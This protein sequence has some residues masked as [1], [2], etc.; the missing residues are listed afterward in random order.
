MVGG[1]TIVDTVEGWL[2]WEHPNYPAYYLPRTAFA[3]RALNPTGV[4]TVHPSLGESELCDLMGHEG[5]ARLFG[6]G[7]GG[8][9][10]DAVR[11][12]WGAVDMWF[13][14]DKQVFVH[15]KDPY[16]RVDIL[17]SS[18]A[19]RIELEGRVLADTDRGTLVLETGLVARWYVPRPDV[20][21][22]LLM[23]STSRTHCPYKGEAMYW[24]LNVGGQIKT[25][26]VRTNP[27]QADIAWSYQTPT[28]ESADLAGLVCFYAERVDTFVDDQEIKRPETPFL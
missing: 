19:V 14:E 7:P 27:A 4:P 26:S 3:E 11:V 22:N 9:M 12:E 24:G 21:F 15:P 2:V 6:S 20:R 28:Q 13:E 18:R 5:S 23:A 1:A 10:T 8:S 17:A 16:K 25:D